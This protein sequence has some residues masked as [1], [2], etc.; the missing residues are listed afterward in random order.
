MGLSTAQRKT[1][2]LISVLLINHFQL[3]FRDIRSRHSL[4]FY[5]ALGKLNRQLHILRLAWVLGLRPQTRAVT[6]LAAEMQNPPQCVRRALMRLAL[7]G[8]GTLH[9]MRL[10]LSGDLQAVKFGRCGMKGG[11]GCRQR[12]SCAL[13]PG[14]QAASGGQG[15]DHSTRVGACVRRS[16]QLHSI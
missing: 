10:R 6:R 12:R 2:R 16:S 3:P 13:A 9:R 11:L 15:H 7:N 1:R 8:G 5:I 4:M 14:K